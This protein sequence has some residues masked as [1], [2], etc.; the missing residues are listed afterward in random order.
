MSNKDKIQITIF[1]H[2]GF[3]GKN[4]LLKLR[5]KKQKI[6]LPKRNILKY[7]INLG[8]II[9]CIGSHQWRNDPYNA[10][11]TDIAIIANILKNNNY[12]S[13]NLISSTRIYKNK[14]TNEDSEISVNPINNDDYYN[15][16][17]IVAENLVL[18]NKKNKVIRISNIFGNNYSST[19]FLPTIIRDAVHKKKIFLTTNKKSEKDFLFVDEA[20]E[21]IIK[22]VKNGS[23]NIYNVAYGKNYL[24]DDI[25]K[26]LKNITSSKIIYKYKPSIVKNSVINIARIKKEFNFKP[27]T[28]VLKYLKILVKNYKESLNKKIS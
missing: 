6:F 16:L 27:K 18:L 4:I 9:Y 17:K 1:G 15:C 12:K 8:H 19:I 25:V 24:I 5:L 14:S 2:K 22:I 11:N 3:I 23:K 20:A 10:F 13:F 21:V 26:H 28:N 7:K